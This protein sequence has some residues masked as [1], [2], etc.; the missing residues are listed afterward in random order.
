MTWGSDWRNN[1]LQALLSAY[2]LDAFAWMLLTS[3]ERQLEDF[4]GRTSGREHQFLQVLTAAERGG[5]LDRLVRG[6][7]DKQPDNPAMRAFF[8]TYQAKSPTLPG[9]G[10]E[11]PAPGGRLW[12]PYQVMPLPHHYVG[13][14]EEERRLQALLLGPDSGR[15]FGVSALF[16]QG[17]IG[18]STL[19]AAVVHNPEVQGQ[20]PDGILWA[21]L[22]QNPEVQSLLTGWVR[23]LGDHDFHGHDAHSAH[24][25]LCGL[26]RSRR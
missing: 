9:P 6:A 19:A 4:P 23:A 13:R 12:V 24:E 18:K 25:H 21:T 22:G 16:G 11:R 7:H 8:Q 2:D 26:L 10:T 1:F 14:P 15:G 20:Y 5:W 3:C 17:G